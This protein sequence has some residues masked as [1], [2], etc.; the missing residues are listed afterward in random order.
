MYYCK[1]NRAKTYIRSGI[2][3]MPV[4]GKAVVRLWRGSRLSSLAIPSAFRAKKSWLCSP[5]FLPASDNTA[6]LCSSQFIFL[7]HHVM[8]V[9]PCLTS[10]ILCI[11][12]SDL[13]IVWEV[14][15]YSQGAAGTVNTPRRDAEPHR[16]HLSSTSKSIHSCLTNDSCLSISCVY[17]IYHSSIRY[18]HAPW[19]ES[20]SLG[21]ANWIHTCANK[22]HHNEKQT[23]Q[24]K[25]W[26]LK[27]PA[28]QSAR[29]CKV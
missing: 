12:T 26:Y 3:Y 23:W 22:T 1:Q 10:P 15:S 9:M 21:S 7:C 5:K 24:A 17:S 14:D 6:R 11:S 4:I 16:A 20:P 8:I 2:W 13:F 18:V 27:E 19:V 29:I 25:I 28:K